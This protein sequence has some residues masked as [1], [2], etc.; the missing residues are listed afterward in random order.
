MKLAQSSKW[1][2]WAYLVDRSKV[3]YGEVSLCVLFWRIVLITPVKLLCGTALILAGLWAIGMIA[4]AT[5]THWIGWVIMGALAVLIAGS[6]LYESRNVAHSPVAEYIKARK[7][8][9]CPIIDITTEAGEK[10]K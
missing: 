5:V 1:I 8:G 4:V 9:I 7:R 3:P 10:E 2:K 6:Y